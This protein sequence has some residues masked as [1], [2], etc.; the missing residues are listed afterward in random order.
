VKSLFQADMCCT[1]YQFRYHSF[2]KVMMLSLT[3]L[4]SGRKD[5]WAF[6]V[7]MFLESGKCKSCDKCVN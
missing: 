3:I 1:E 7:L 4:G 6:F 2:M 5:K